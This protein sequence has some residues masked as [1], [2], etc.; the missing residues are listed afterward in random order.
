VGF[1]PGGA[2]DLSARII[3]RKMAEGMGAVFVIENRPGAGGNIAAQI[4][5]SANADGHTL[6]WGSVGPLTVSPA[7]GVKLPYDAFADFSPVGL[8]VNSCNVLVARPGF[9]A[10]SV[11]ELVALAK[12]KPG[13]LNYASQGTGSTGH[14]AGELLKTLTGTDIVHIGYRGGAEV[15]TSVMSGEMALAFVSVTGLRGMAE[16]VKPLAITCSKRDAGLPNLP[17]FAE[18]GVKNYEATFWYGLLAPARTAAPVVTL[19]NTRLRAAV[20]DPAIAQ[21]LEIQGLTP[22]PTSPS[23]FRDII[24]ADY[25]KWK[26]VFGGKTGER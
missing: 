13:Q 15:V 4:V 6:F 9:P 5:A 10:S 20:S 19:L 7:M 25:R 8:A 14:L 3:T 22:A 11:S 12:A 18:S 2:A 24:L 26:L 1:T 17:T 23:G 21:P 16:R